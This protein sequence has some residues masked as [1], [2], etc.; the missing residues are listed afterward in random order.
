MDA[1]KIVLTDRDTRLLVDLYTHRF[2]TIPQLR[3]THFVSDQTAF[4]RVR[5]LR[6]TGL[7]D[8]FQVPN[9]PESIHRLTSKGLQVVAESLGV[10]RDDLKWNEPSTKPRDYYFMRHFL[11]INDF[12][13]ALRIECQKHKVTLCGFI[14]DYI[15]ERTDKGGIVKYVKDVIC[16]K[17]ADR[18]E[19]SHTPDGAFALEREGR[20]ALFFLEIDRGTEVVSDENKGVLKMLRFYSQY[21]LDGKYQRYTKDFGVDAFKGFRSLIVTTTSARMSNIRAATSKLIVDRKSLRFQWITTGDS[22]SK[23]GIFGK[24]WRSADPAD[25]EWYQIVK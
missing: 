24:I 1:K 3:L 15:G 6:Q 13:I 9:I 20:T 16:D 4:R 18:Q 7:I 12:R 5:Q 14:P 19:L 8:S 23:G 10:E 21:L 25:E 2:L 17:S 11:A 22:L